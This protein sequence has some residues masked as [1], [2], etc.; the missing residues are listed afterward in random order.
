[1]MEGF[2]VEGEHIEVREAIPLSI[3][4]WLKRELP[5]PDRLLG[6]WLTTTSRTIM[7]AATGIGKTNFGLAFAAHAAAGVDFLHWRAHRSCR[8]LF[9]DGE[10]SRGLLK[11]RVGD[12]VRR[13]R[14]VPDGLYLLSHEDFEDFRPLNTPEGVAFISRI[15]QDI[16]GIDLA[17]FD[18][19]M[20][21][22]VGN[23][24]DPDAWAA[25]EPLVK[26]L[27]KSAIG[28][29]WIDHTGHDTNRGYG[30]NT[31]TWRMDT[32]IHLTEVK[33][34]GTDVSFSLEFRKARG[35]T[36][37]TRRDFEDVTIALVNDEWTSSASAGH[38]G[39]ASP[40]GARFLESLRDAMTAGPTTTFQ[41][42][43][44]IKDEYWRAECVTRGLID[45]SKPD[46]A[47]TLF[48]KHKRELI[49]H[50]LISCNNDLVWLQ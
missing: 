33:R 19:I 14:A 4:A 3:E 29:V 32:V 22:T 35:R 42:W 26:Q 6:E 7:S 17:V 46:S 43:N 18:N 44:A 31:K 36:P 20:S 45:P 10:M 21:L 23:Q 47:R 8:V 37:E 25:T 39:K 30:S 49:G 27:T 24:K 11:L 34:A 9:V 5:V 15:I 48:N 41:K 13:L 2:T 16:G 28:Q 50:N 12:A 38:R 40:L 1:M